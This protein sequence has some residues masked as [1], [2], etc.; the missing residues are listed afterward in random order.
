MKEEFRKL[1][2]LN[3][4]NLPPSVSFGSEGTK[5]TRADYLGNPSRVVP[6]ADP[7]ITSEV[8]VAQQAMALKQMAATTPGYNQ[9][10]VERRV[11]KAMHVDDVDSVYPGV[12]SPLATPPPPNPKMEVE[13]LKLQAKQAGFDLQRQLTGMTLMETHRLNTAKI[14]ELQASALKLVE[15]AGGVKESQQ[16]QAFNAAIGAMKQHND[17]ILK[18]IEVFL[19]ATEQGAGNEQS[20]GQGN[21]AGAMESLAAGPSDA[22]PAGMVEVAA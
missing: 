9:E 8:Q 10:T 12:K 1:Y 19:S 2:I 16:L 4:I 21:L 6:V 13:Q 22:G 17:T 15:E 5:V 18:Q 14:A 7:N 3:A 11:L 20:A